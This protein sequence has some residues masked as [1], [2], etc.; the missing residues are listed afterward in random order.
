[1]G[2]SQL[3][4]PTQQK[5]RNPLARQATAAALGDSSEQRSALRAKAR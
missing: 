5:R 4:E 2:V 1:M 3:D